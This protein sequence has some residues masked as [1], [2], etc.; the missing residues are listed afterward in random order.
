MSFFPKDPVKIKARIKSYESALKKEYKTHGF[1]DDG[2]GKRYLI[3][4]LYVLLGDY[5]GA[6]KHFEWFEKTFPDDIGDPYQYLCWILVLY[7][8]GD[9]VKAREKVFQTMFMN[10]YLIPC[11]LGID[12]PNLPIWHG[13]NLAEKL[14]ALECP[15]ELIKLWDIDARN[16]LNK[17]WFHPETEKIRIQYISLLKDLN[18]EDDRDKRGNILNKI[19]EL[20]NRPN[21]K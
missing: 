12:Q 15:K 3:G 6:I 17:V 5:E 16:Y 8:V 20:K 18:K 14:Y 13:S 2:Y 9:Q 4:L 19:R 11:V 1:Y 21:E 7:K 10:L